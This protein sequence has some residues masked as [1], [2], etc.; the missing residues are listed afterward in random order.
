[1]IWTLMFVLSGIGVA[2]GG[3]SL[4]R[5]GVKKAKNNHY[6]SDDGFG[7][8]VSGNLLITVGLLIAILG[9][10]ATAVDR[11]ACH[12]YGRSVGYATEWE[13]VGGCYVQVADRLVPKDW[14]VPV[15]E[16]ELL[17][18]EIQQPQG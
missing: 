15:F 3:V 4:L 1:M 5:V 12:R 13:L 18:V 14:V 10:S 16:G 2:A 11:A 6:G 7:W 17:R 8:K 9:G